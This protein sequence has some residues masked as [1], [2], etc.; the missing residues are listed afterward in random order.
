[1]P[2]FNKASTSELSFAASAGLARLLTKANPMTAR[3]LERPV[4]RLVR[5]PIELLTVHDMLLDLTCRQDR[6]QR[7]RETELE[8][9]DV[10]MQLAT[11]ERPMSCV[12]GTSAT[13]RREKTA[14]ARR[15]T[16]SSAALVC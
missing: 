11:T 8:L 6:P 12:F 14:P 3:M 16:S 7:P 10:V 2:R 5:E 1:M 9:D 4:R 13:H 15:D